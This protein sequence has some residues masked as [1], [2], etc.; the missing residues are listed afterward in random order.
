MIDTSLLKST[1]IYTLFNSTI[2]LKPLTYPRGGMNMRTV[3]FTTREL[4]EEFEYRISRLKSMKH[5]NREIVCNHDYVT[6][7]SIPEDEIES[8]LSIT[9][10]NV[11]DAI[12]YL[13][14]DFEFCQ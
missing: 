10:N 12:T 13:N 14:D 9:F 4:F 11:E 8:W 7:L 6:E 2:H 5:S 1:K 3:S